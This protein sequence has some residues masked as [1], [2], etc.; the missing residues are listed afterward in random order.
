MR[1]QLP[2][3]LRGISPETLFAGFIL[4][5]VA[6][7]TI[8][9]LLAAQNLPVDTIEALLWGQEWQAGYHKH[10]PLS[11]WAAEIVRI[12]DAHWPLFALSQ[13]FVAIAFVAAWALAR[14]ILDPWRA[15]IAV[16]AMAAVH[17]HSFSSIE[18]NANVVQYPFWAIAGLAFWR[19]M[20][21][22]EGGGGIFWWLVLGLAC[23]GGI[24]GKH[25][26][27][28]LPA[29]MGLFLL[30]HPDGRRMLATPGPWL[31]AAIC[32]ALLVPHLLWNIA[33]GFPSVSYA[34]ERGDAGQVGFVE[35]LANAVQFTGAQ[36]LALIPLLLLLLVAG[37]P[38]PRWGRPSRDGWL[39]ITIG[40]GPF[41]G[42]VAS[43]LV[44]GIGL[45]D[46]WGAPLFLLVGPLL[47]VFLDPKPLNPRRFAIGFAVLFGLKIVGYAVATLLVPGFNGAWERIH[48]PGREF[49][50][51]VG[52]GWRERFDA[53]LAIAVGDIWAAGNVSFYGRERP[54]VYIDADPASALW[55]DDEQVRAQGAVVVWLSDKRGRREIA[56]DESALA[57][58]R[59][60][61]PEI[62]EMPALTA[63][64]RWLGGS[65]PVTMGWAVIP[66]RGA[67][68]GRDR[69]ARLP[70]GGI[71][72]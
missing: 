8:L 4:L 25:S 69:R 64:A 26:F 35:I 33:H 21:Q 14:D 31:A 15:L 54:S 30:L 49:A 29:A 17:Y 63:H 55:L 42:F 48:F 13:I 57:S 22:G 37:R 27:A 67:E 10:P 36:M 40:L 19:A 61:F 58:L 9:P 52:E 60:R 12:E 28:L 59:E 20:R 62:E 34:A 51:Q 32:A 3:R 18:F 38:A 39:L 43:A 66:P 1:D 2:E 71:P 23:A 72:E 45:R 11:A 7:W 65:A 56:L 6:I 53:P 5:H 46:M 24:L 70:V 50:A 16:A 44:L 68:A 41:I 47:M